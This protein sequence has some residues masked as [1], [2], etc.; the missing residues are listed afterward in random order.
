MINACE[1]YYKNKDM[2]PKL[3]W[4]NGHGS[5]V[6]IKDDGNEIKSKNKLSEMES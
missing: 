3:T 5:I 6:E 2:S 1:Y 4:E